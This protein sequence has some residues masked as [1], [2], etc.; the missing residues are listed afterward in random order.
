LLVALFFI[1]SSVPQA[2]ARNVPPMGWSY[3]TTEATIPVALYTLPNGQGHSFTEAQPYQGWPDHDA[4]IT[5]TVQNS[6]QE[7]I[8]DYPCEDLWLESELGGLMLPCPGGTTADYNTDTNGQTQFQL[9]LRAGG[10]SSPTSNERLQVMISGLPLEQPGLEIYVNSPDIDGDG[11][12]T[13]ADVILF[14][15]VFLDPADHDFYADFWW[16]GYVNLHD[17]VLFAQGY[18]AECP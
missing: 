1:A 5:L 6:A 13:L 14:A 8:A 17:L 18:R 15:Q 3:A 11:I 9:P 10:A 7:P 12:V 4:T 16:D 2:I